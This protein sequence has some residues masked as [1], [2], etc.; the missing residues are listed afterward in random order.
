MRYAIAQ[1][2]INN[3]SA[4]LAE[5][6]ASSSANFSVLADKVNSTL[7]GYGLTRCQSRHLG[8][9]GASAEDRIDA[10]RKGHCE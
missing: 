7:V 6:D 10:G 3:M 9:T 1:D 2:N 8:E 5:I 4:L